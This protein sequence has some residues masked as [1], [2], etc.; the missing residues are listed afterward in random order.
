MR[1]WAYEVLRFA[2]LAALAALLLVDA[3]LPVC[4]TPGEP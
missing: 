3:T 4:S 1:L 2:A